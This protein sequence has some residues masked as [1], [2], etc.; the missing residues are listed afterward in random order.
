MAF[1]FEVGKTYITQEG[2]AVKVLGR[3]ALPGYECLKCSDEVF[4]YDRS[5]SSMDAGRVTGTNHDYS[6]PRNFKRD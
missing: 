6:D 3:T 1:K 5:D 2:N 4:R